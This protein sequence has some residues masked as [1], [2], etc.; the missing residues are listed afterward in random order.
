M[1]VRA[2]TLIFFP[3][4]NKRQ[5]ITTRKR[6]GEKKQERERE[7]ERARLISFGFI[8][9]I[10]PYGF[11]VLVAIVV[12]CLKQQQQHRR[13]QFMKNEKERK[14]KQNERNGKVYTICIQ[15]YTNNNKT[16]I[17]VSRAIQ[18][19]VNTWRSHNFYEH[20]LNGDNSQPKQYSIFEFH[21]RWLGT[22]NKKYLFS[23]F[24]AGCGCCRCFNSRCYSVL[25]R[26]I[27]FCFVLSQ[28][29]KTVFLAVVVSVI[30]LNLRWRQKRRMSKIYFE[31]RE[32]WTHN[33]CHRFGV[34]LL[35]WLLLLWSV[36]ATEIGFFWVNFLRLVWCCVRAH[37]FV[38]LHNFAGR[39]IPNFIDFIPFALFDK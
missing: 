32:L 13:K 2:R 34:F 11:T 14:I 33:H 16:I 22:A 36:R 6:D 10:V 23:R 39:S 30:T 5:R 28:S 37:C 18:F 4:L 29:C 25:L 31:A 35:L 3:F 26:S 17:Y 21:D 9:R 20:K 24:V 15:K 1:S 12:D 8:L 38:L 19:D 7:G 27:S